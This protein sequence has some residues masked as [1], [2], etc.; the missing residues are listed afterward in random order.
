MTPVVVFDDASPALTPLTDLRPSFNVRTGALTTLERAAAALAVQR[1]TIASV[2][3][4]PARAELTREQTTLPVNTPITGAAILL[5]GRCVIPPDNLADLPLNAGI[6]GES[7]AVVAV[8]LGAVDARAFLDTR[9]LPSS[10]KLTPAP[11]R[12]LLDRPWDVITFRDRAL[13]HDLAHLIRQRPPAPIPAHVT[14]IAPDNVR[15]H[16]SARLSP[17][18]LIDAEAGPVV[19]D[20]GAAVRPG[21]IIIGPAY[22][23]PRSTLLERALIKPHTAVGHVCKV[24]GEVGGTI[25]QGFANKAHDGHLGDSWVGEWVNFGAGTTNS[26]LLNTYAEVTATLPLPG[27]GRERTSLT[28]LGCIVG[29]HTKFAIATRIMTASIFGTGCMVASTAPPPTSLARFTWLTDSRAQPYRFAKFMDVARA[30]MARRS[31]TPSPALEA[32]LRDL[33]PA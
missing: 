25:F 22:I 26:N 32:A 17:S 28:Y 29:D 24:T 3:V 20:H 31:V 11:E 23:G 8:H 12:C 30:V 4:P 27:A 1:L 18:V 15:V 14:V 10:I 33:C 6:L 19:I 5:N 21:S 13:D 7:G 2:H 9:A 16:P